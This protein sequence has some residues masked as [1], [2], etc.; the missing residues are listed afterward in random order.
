MPTA[1]ANPEPHP[2]CARDIRPRLRHSAAIRVLPG[3]PRHTSAQASSRYAPGMVRLRATSATLGP[4][5][6]WVAHPSSRAPAAAPA[7]RCDVGAAKGCWPRRAGAQCGDGREDCGGSAR[8]GPRARCAARSRSVQAQGR[9]PSQGSP[10]GRCRQGGRNSAPRLSRG[11]ADSRGRARARDHQV[12]VSRDVC[13]CASEAAGE[14]RVRNGYIDRAA[15]RGKVDTSWPA[16]RLVRRRFYLAYPGLG[17][18]R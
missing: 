7:L 15:T 17:E 8:V 12:T 1:S 6:R 11:R 16:R 9:R 14:Q 2:I 4:A 10:R 5:R 13:D 18:P 3:Q